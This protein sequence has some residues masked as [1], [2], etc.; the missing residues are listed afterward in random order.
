METEQ[1]AKIVANIIIND[2]MKHC[3]EK[4]CKVNELGLS[5]DDIG[6]LAG[7]IYYNVL[8]RTKVTKIIDHFMEFGGEVKEIISSLGLW[9]TYDD[10]AL[11]EAVNKVISDNPKI[12]EQIL[13]GKE[14]AI[15]SLVGRLKQVDRNIDSKEA[16][17]LL[18]EKIYG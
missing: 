17:I 15:G 10:G 3:N 13:E 6:W 12:I 8:D 14:K 16:M 4:S 18:K 5:S 2:L 1:F 7:L 11:E 9:P